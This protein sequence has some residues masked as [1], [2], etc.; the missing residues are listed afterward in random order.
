MTTR[1]VDILV[2]VALDQTYSYRVPAGLDLAPGNLV[3]VP[4]GAR[5][6]TGVVWAENPA[7]NP[8]LH[9][10]LRDVDEKLDVPPLRT[11][12]RQ[13]VDWVSAYTLASRGMVLRMA[14][15]MGEHSGAGREQTGVR[16]AGPAPPR[17]RSTAAGAAGEGADVLT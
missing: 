9:N 11:E 6:C 10:R 5:E 4:L 16:L 15:R 14:L 1:V 17:A 12:L 13:F 2:P 8:R 3:S 7:P